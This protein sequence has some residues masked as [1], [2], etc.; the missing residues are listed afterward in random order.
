MKSH[1][2]LFSNTASLE[3]ELRDI[4][5]LHDGLSSEHFVFYIT[6]SD[7]PDRDIP[8]IARCI[9]C[10]FPDSV[11]YGN[12]VTASIIE[13]THRY[14]IFICCYVLEDEDSSAR[15]LWVEQGTEYPSLEDLWAY[16][17]TQEE[18]KGVEL[19]IPSS[20]DNEVSQIY[21]CHIDLNSSILVFGGLSISRSNLILESQVFAK[22]H[23]ITTKGTVAVLYFGRNLHIASNYI[24]GWKGLGRYMTVTG[25][26]GTLIREI[27]G[28]KPQDIYRKYLNLTDNDSANTLV[29][30]LMLEEDG[31]EYLRTPR[32]FFPDKSVQM[33][34]PVREDSLVR[35][36]YGDKNTILN[37]LYD[38]T[39]DIESFSPEIVK[40][41][42][43]AARKWFWGDDEVSRET[44]P[45]QEIAPTN[46]FYTGGE[47]LR[48]GDKVR[49]MNSTLVLI[50]FR[51][52]EGKPRVRSTFQK[53][54]DSSLL[55][56]ITYF[57]GKI[58]QEQEEALKIANEEKQRNDL[59]HSIIHS[60]KWSF[61][62]NSRD[63]IIGA[64]LDRNGLQLTDYDLT[65][66]P[67]AW[68]E[69]IHPDDKNFVIDQFFA[70][71]RDR[72]CKTP[73]DTTYRMMEKDGRFHWFH[74]AGRMMR[75]EHG[76]GEFFGIHIDIS[77]Q[78]EK[79]VENQKKLEEALNMAQAANKSKTTFLFNMSHDIRTPMNAIKGFT[80]MAKRNCDDKDKVMQYLDKID[81]A[82][83]QLLLLI[84]QVLE[85][86]RIETGRTEFN[87]KPINLQERYESLV[88]IVSE[89][90]KEKG[91]KF[92]HKLVDIVHYN[93]LA[94]EAKMSQITLNIIGNAIK[95]TPAGGSIDSWLKETECDRRGYARFVFTV[96]DTGI[97]ISK[98]FQKVLF[99]P[100]T[101]EKS[102]TVSKIQGTGLG[103]SIVKSLLELIGG[104]IEVQSE[105]GK[106]TRFDLTV[107]FK[108]DDSG[109]DG[110]AQVLP[111]RTCDLKGRR[112]LL[113]EDN[114]LNREIARFILEDMGLIVEEA[115]DGD[116]AV[117][118]IEELFAKGEYDR[119]D[120]ILMDIQMPVMDGYEATR[121]IR[122]IDTAAGI[123]LTILAM[124][125]NAFEEDR[126]NAMASGMDGHL[127]KPIDVAKLKETLVQFAK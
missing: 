8:E 48:I 74:S 101:R 86:S 65:S 30:P 20:S 122:K 123:H 31:V 11:Y 89:Q 106:G 95:Y 49:I 38:R 40:S 100:F 6:W 109:N 83:Q 88:T 62:I 98:E 77:D 76:N 22:G 35:I 114:A 103:L 28:Q 44:L 72:S 33:I 36:A 47:I 117:R 59:M 16:C 32:G 116:I 125:A 80:A 41:F 110:R 127:A 23:P 60:Y 7:E 56:R 81:L 42:S 105:P 96:Q 121:K 54:G 57:A 87:Y 26:A 2:I 52:G 126:K 75:D 118:M 90:A 39:R 107:D 67:L 71:I 104:K 61:R 15:L 79:Q 37:S 45:I 82:G 111:A 13:G 113:V 69:I 92:T 3:K 84:N 21:D 63:E 5:A 50:S 102:S 25:S 120:Y 55:A 85:M 18:L 1:Q 99:E 78:I 70:A 51:E 10:V 58:V 108:I 19:L 115:E 64:D 34:V 4:R 29:F 12:E 112:V 91:L 43:C 27:D 46:G 93:L 73:Y 124:T 119:Y 53:K 9:E 68:T 66:S 24:L 97:G 14:G 17:R 94:D